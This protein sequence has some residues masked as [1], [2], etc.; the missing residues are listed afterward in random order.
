MIRFGLPYRW[1]AETGSTNDVARDW[2]RAGAPA[3]ALVVAGR[4]THGRG[5]RA[6]RWASPS[7]CG[8]YA[9]FILRPGWLAKKAPHLAI[10]GGMATYRALQ[11][12]GVPQ[13]RVKWPNDILADGLKIAGVLV[14]PSI[15]LERIEFAVVGIGINIGQACRDFPFELRNTAT[16]CHMAGVAISVDEMLAGLI[17]SWEAVEAVPF[18]DLC[19]EWVTAGAKEQEPPI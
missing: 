9:S 7:G 2:A 4:Q 13:L 19:A 18:N 6:S 10:L 14:E 15:R 11:T 8:L 16:S 17:R 1:L 3:G 12:A 5:R